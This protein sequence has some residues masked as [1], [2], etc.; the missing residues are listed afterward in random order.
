[1][2]AFRQR[3]ALLMAPRSCQ[4]PADWATIAGPDAG[5]GA[6]AANAGAVPSP[7]AMTAAPSPAA[8]LV[9]MELIRFCSLH[10]GEDVGTGEEAAGRRLSAGYPELR[11]AEP[12]ACHPIRAPRCSVPNRCELRSHHG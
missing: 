1:M 10:G 5:L 6:G 12:H 11:Q 2:T 7:R 3:R 8:A 4:C 9:M